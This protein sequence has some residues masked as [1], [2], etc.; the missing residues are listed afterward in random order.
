MTVFWI[1]FL[2][3]YVISGLVVC[4]YVKTHAGKWVAWVPL[5]NTSVIVVALWIVFILHRRVYK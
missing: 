2:I 4:T 5:L 1:W 3:V